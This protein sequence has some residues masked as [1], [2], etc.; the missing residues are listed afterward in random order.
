MLVYGQCNNLRNTDL[1]KCDPILIVD[2]LDG[3]TKAMSRLGKTEWL[4]DN[5]NPEFETKIAVEYVFE[6]MQI[7]RI[8]VLN[9]DDEAN[10]PTE[11]TPNVM[12]N[13]LCI[14]LIIYTFVCMI[15]TRLLN[16]REQRVTCWVVQKSRFQRSWVKVVVLS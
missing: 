7:L 13:S 4:R 1:G 15:L 5:L 14:I 6:K 9:V 10:I 16:G 11:Y 8:T 2:I 12:L 3:Q